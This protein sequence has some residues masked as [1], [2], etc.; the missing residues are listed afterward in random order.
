MSNSDERISVAP[1]DL[2]DCGMAKAAEMLGDKWRLLILREAFY[3][4]KRFDDLKN[5]ANI[6]RATL[7]N[8]LKAMV[9]DGLL[10]GI[11]YRE[12]NARARTE[13]CLTNRGRA[14]AKILL[15]MMYWA[16]EYL[17][18]GKTPLDMVC[19][20]TGAVLDLAFV[21]PDGLI[22]AADGI[23]PRINSNN[24]HDK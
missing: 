18:E 14:T 5:D 8:R 7:A 9:K 15:A 19:G 22:V 1:I 11:E 24:R 17:G 13:Y 2:D 21:G 23:L 6:P 3:G 4:V 20:E 10:E 16:D 12:G